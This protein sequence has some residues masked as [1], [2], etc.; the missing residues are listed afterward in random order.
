MMTKD[1]IAQYL[2]QNRT[3]KTLAPK[4]IGLLAELAS[5]V[6]FAPDKFLYR[7]DAEANEFHVLLQGRVSLEIASPN[8]R[9]IVVQTLGADQVLGWSWL[10]APYRRR[11]D[12]RAA[13]E[14]RA[15]VIDAK[16]LRAFCEQDKEL[17]YA[18]LKILSSVLA[19]RLRATQFQLLDLYNAT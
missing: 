5:E 7:E 18:L 11:F 17:G 15:L 19:D 10:F 14:T 13:E 6:T 2:A 8:R 9:P 3:F 4:Q 12:V 1:S 16:R